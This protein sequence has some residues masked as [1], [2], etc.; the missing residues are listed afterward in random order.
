MI[1]KNLQTLKELFQQIK[2]PIFGVGVY[3]FHRLGLEDI[4]SKYRI[5]AL[6]YS[7]DTKLIEENIRVFSLGWVLW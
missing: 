3:A 4:V 2:T 6:R 1:V 7:L 5:L